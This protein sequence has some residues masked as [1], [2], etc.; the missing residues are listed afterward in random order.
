MLG[1]LQPADP[2]SVGPYRLLGWLG[3]GGMG[4]VY[5]GRSA[6][7]RLV[8]V[9][10]IRPE[11]AAEPGFRMRFAR[12]VAAARNVSGLFTALVV[13]ADVS[14]P[15]PWLATTYVTGPSLAKAVADEGPL[16]VA[17]VLSLAAGLVEGLEAI[18]AAGLVHRDLKP[19]NVLLADDGPRVIDFGISRVAEAGAVTQTGVVL[20]SPGFMSPEQAEGGATGPPS[21][22]FSLGAVLTFAATGEGPFGNGSTPALL[23]RVV[24]RPPDVARLPGQIRPLVERCLVKDPGLRPTTGDLLAALSAGRRSADLAPP[25]G[26]PAEPPT[27][28]GL[29]VPRPPAPP[30][31]LEQFFAPKEAGTAADGSAARQRQRR[32]RR[33]LALVAVALVAGVMTASASASIDL[34]SSGGPRRGATGPS[35]PSRIAASAPA[36]PTGSRSPTISPTPSP[37]S[38]AQTQPAAPMNSSPTSPTTTSPPTTSPTTTG[39]PTPSPTS[40]SPTSPS[41]TSPSPTTS[42]PTPSPTH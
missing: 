3:A 38:A 16:P 32:N 1:E 27:M 4:Q 12:E 35:P 25:A 34:S 10:V 17:S 31:A 39:S 18:H 6:G 22:V 5:L 24:H 23:Y 19:S 26:F 13:D 41:P 40:P 14:G 29:S 20:G 11:F 2:R 42:P 36:H 33:R 15:V 30:S 37:T 7:G 21:D 28:I 8:A 9:K